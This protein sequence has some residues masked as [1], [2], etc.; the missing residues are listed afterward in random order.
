MVGMGIVLLKEIIF[1]D[2]S[3]YNTCTLVYYVMQDN[4]FVIQV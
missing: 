1:H 2:N 3:N 4:K